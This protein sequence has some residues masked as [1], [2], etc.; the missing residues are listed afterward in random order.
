MLVME[1]GTSRIQYKAT[2]RAMLD[3][4]YTKLWHDITDLLAA[5]TTVEQAFYHA[6]F[7]HMVFVNIH[8][9]GDGNGRSGRLL[10]KWFLAEKLGE[11]AWYIQSELHY[12]R[13]VSNYYRGLNRLGQF[14]ENLD[15]SKA[16]PFLL[17]LP[18][19]L[20]EQGQ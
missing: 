18:Q 4:E 9:F 5:D 17:M 14:Y 8:P 12:L 1:N 2:P 19:S 6:A 15:Y 10:E 7:I 20:V 16:L 3:T 13:N 11:R